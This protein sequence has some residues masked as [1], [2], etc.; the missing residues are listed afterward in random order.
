MLLFLSN[1]LRFHGS[2]FNRFFCVY[3]WTPGRRKL[4]VAAWNHNQS[5]IRSRWERRRPN[6]RWPETVKPLSDRSRPRA[7]LQQHVTHES[8][9]THVTV[10]FDDMSEQIYTTENSQNT[11]QEHSDD[12]L[13]PYLSILK[14]RREIDVAVYL[15]HVIGDRE[16]SPS[17]KFSS[18][19]VLWTFPFCE[20]ASQFCQSQ[21]SNVLFILCRYVTYRQSHSFSFPSAALISEVLLTFPGLRTLGLNILALSVM[22]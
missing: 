22:K 2:A 16:N 15:L 17:S 9:T 1:L 8:A 7:S 21:L 10:G 12:A 18:V 20:F 5:P 4:R 14:V 13:W 6:G 3:V 19:L 11:E